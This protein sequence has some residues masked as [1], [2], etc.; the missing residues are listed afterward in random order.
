MA[1]RPGQA[2]QWVLPAAGTFIAL[3]GVLAVAWI[4]NAFAESVF[5]GKLV[6]V[7]L[8]LTLVAFAATLAAVVSLLVTTLKHQQQ[9]AATGLH[10]QLLRRQSQLLESIHES[11][12]VSDRA[13]AV[14]FR[15]KEREALRRA[16]Q[17]DITKGDWEAAYHL[18]D[19]MARA[20]GYHEEAE[21]L[22]GEIDRQRAETLKAELAGEMGAFRENLSARNWEAARTEAERLMGMFPGNREVRDLGNRIQAA[23]DGHKRHLLTEFQQTIDRS[24]LDRGIELLK[25]LDEY[26]T[27]GEAEGLREAARG[28]FRAKLHNLGVQFSIAVSEKNWDEAIA[29]GQQ[30]IEEFPN[31]RMAQEV[32]DNIEALRDR[33]SAV[34]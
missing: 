22:R 17:E 6:T 30:I 3:S 2:G 26:L 20:F 14:A 12:L 15:E 27:P 33:A 21:R 28:V 11:V 9:A 25:E 24:Q 31:S 34:R 29:A 19:E 13:K 23:W 10:E 32:R 16:I 5:L 1:K 7:L 18:V 4:V 8:A